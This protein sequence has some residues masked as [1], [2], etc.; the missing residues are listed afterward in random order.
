MR[1]D[2]HLSW[3]G[4]L[5]LCHSRLS[6]NMRR[7]YEMHLRDCPACE[8]KLNRLRDWLARPS[9]PMDEHDWLRERGE[10]TCTEDAPLLEEHPELL[11]RAL[12]KRTEPDV[13]APEFFRELFRHI[14]HCYPCF[15]SYS[16]HAREAYPDYK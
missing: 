11:L 10:Q 8:E 4:L 3:G 13:R 12:D 14:V 5:A 1:R 15:A 7:R 16:H 6:G 2:A 9:T